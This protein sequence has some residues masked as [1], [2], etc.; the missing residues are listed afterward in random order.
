M[1]RAASPTG[2]FLFLVS[3]LTVPVPAAAQDGA[4][5]LRQGD[6][7]A[8]LVLHAEPPVRPDDPADPESRV[9]NAQSASFGPFLTPAEPTT[10]HLPGGAVQMVVFLSTGPQGMA[11]CAEV[12]ASL[13]RTLP[14]GGSTQIMPPVSVAGV[15]LQ[16][17]NDDP[18]PVE[19]SLGSVPPLALAPG[20]RLALL[21]VVR[22][23]CGEGRNVS[24]SF[25]AATHASRLAFPDNCPTVPNPDQLDSDGDGLGDACDNCDTIASVDQRD[26]DGDGVGDACDVCVGLANPDQRDLDRDGLGD[27]CDNCAAL[28]SLDQRNGDG[29]ALGDLCDHCPA[30][31]GPGNGCPCTASS[32]DDG[33]TCTT[34]TCDAAVGCTHSV[35]VSFDAVSCKLAMLRQA[36]ADASATDLTPRLARPKSG[37][38]RALARAGR[39]VSGA[40]RDFARGKLRRA[41]RRIVG[42]QNALEQFTTRVGRAQDR[43]QLSL[44]L[45]ATLDRLTGDALGV[46]QKLP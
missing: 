18:P 12:T 3:L 46:V 36:L 44:D 6:S 11:G 14:A 9:P 20:E 19:V 42:L 39:L 38:R 35:A 1:S 23:T 45:K 33:D 7:R 21:V 16:P 15:T 8:N 25:D 30:E 13:F 2:A 27:A 28:P 10:R 17:K 41:E 26:G 22:N 40:E 43:T 24:L 31:P 32:C 37:L 4:L 5:F 29:D 34:D